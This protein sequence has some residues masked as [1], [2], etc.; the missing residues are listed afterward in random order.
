MEIN[1]G[2]FGSKGITPETFGTNGVDAKR[3]TT[4]AAGI[5]R[6]APNLTIGEGPA[7]LAAAEPVA[8]VSEA[9]AEALAARLS[10]EYEDCDVEYHSGGQPLYYYLISV[11]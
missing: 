9:D 3:G 11:E 8:D 7:G 10:E 2:N 1:I 4:D 6:Q 5:A